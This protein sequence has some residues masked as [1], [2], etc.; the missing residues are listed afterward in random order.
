MW[1]FTWSNCW[2]SDWHS[3][4]IAESAFESGVVVS[5]CAEVSSFARKLPQR[6][7]TERFVELINEP[8]I[9]LDLA[10]LEIARC[11]R[12]DDVDAPASL[13]LLDELAAQV[14]AHSAVNQSATCSPTA[15]SV[16]DLLY[17]QLGFGGDRVDYDQ[18]DNS[19]LDRV[20]VK[21]SGIP[22]TLAV[23]VIEVARRVGVA[24]YPVAMPGHFLVRV[25]NTE[26]ATE[27]SVA[28]S[29]FFDPF[30]GTYLGYSEA[31]MIFKRLRPEWPFRTEYLET[32]PSVMVLRRIL[33]NLRLNYEQEPRFTSL[34]DASGL[35]IVLELLICLPDCLADDYLH[36]ERVLT[37][38]GELDVGIKHLEAG[39]QRLTGS[40]AEALQAAADRLLARLN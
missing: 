7:S 22:I 9:R 2:L 4:S 31:K 15:K 20:L 29:K 28:Q 27:L 30:D 12:P 39:A 35:A 21:R 11:C 3:V 8:K 17:G 37:H 32:I 23:V 18:L 25:P 16:T 14:E 38:L 36:L 5:Y 33:N 34:R 6:A 10:A 1:I 40:D 13:A 19:Y 24:L 26:S